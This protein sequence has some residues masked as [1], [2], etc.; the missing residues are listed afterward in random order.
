M[1]I[2]IGSGKNPL[3]ASEPQFYSVKY[4]FYVGPFVCVVLGF[5]LLC[6]VSPAQFPS[7][8]SF[9]LLRQE[10]KSRFFCG[11]MARGQG[12]AV[13]KEIERKG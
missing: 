3:T 4:I 1:F 2:I 7:R 11:K 5:L 10:V 12:M 8:E 13:F 6:Q 9:D